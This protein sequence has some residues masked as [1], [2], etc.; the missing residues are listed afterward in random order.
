MFIDFDNSVND[1]NNV[2]NCYNINNRYDIYGLDV[3]RSNGNGY[4]DDFDINGI[5]YICY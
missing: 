2:Y 5:S 3:Y 1:I 4:N